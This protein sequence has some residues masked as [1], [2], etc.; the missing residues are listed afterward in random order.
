[1]S[2]WVYILASKRNGTLY[3]GHTENLPERVHEHRTGAK[4]GFASRYGATRLVWVEPHPT[5]EAAKVREKR[6]KA[7]KRAW[8]LKLIEESNPDWDDLY[9]ELNNWWSKEG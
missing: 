9:D 4:P 2:F 5:R 8:K 3:T 6:I 1:M 7:W